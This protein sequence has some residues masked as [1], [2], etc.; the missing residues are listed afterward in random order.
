[1][2][3]SRP[4]IDCLPGAWAGQ[5]REAALIHAVAARRLYHANAA[6]ARP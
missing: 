1:M 2:Q 3:R 4:E 6:T 5:R